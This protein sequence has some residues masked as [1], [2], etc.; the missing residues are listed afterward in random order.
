MASRCLCRGPRTSK[1]TPSRTKGPR[2][3]VKIQL[4]AELFETPVSSALLITLIQYALAGR[5]RVDLDADDPAVAGWIQQ[6]A[7]TIREEI[8]FAIELSAHEEALEP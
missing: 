3:R 6:Q 8:T 4:A 1:G 2:F 7:P 5:H